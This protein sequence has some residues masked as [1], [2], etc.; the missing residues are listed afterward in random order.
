MFQGGPRTC[1]GKEMAFVQMKFVASAVLRRFKF[2][3]VDEGRTPAFVP[4]MTA[5]MAGGLNVTVRRRTPAPAT[6]TAANG[7]GGELTSS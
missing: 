3:P 1:L 7:T 2:R 6:S 5:H 4:L